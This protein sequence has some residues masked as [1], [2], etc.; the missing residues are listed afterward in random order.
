[1]TKSEIME[2]YTMEQLAEMVVKSNNLLEVLKYSDAFIKTGLFENPAVA[3]YESKIE[4][5][6]KENEKLKF[7]LDRKQ[8]EINQI[9]EILNELFGVTHDIAKPAEFEK[10]LREKA[11]DYKTISDFLPEEPIEVASMLINVEKNEE[12]LGIRDA[13]HIFDISELRQIAEHLLVYCNANKSEEE[14]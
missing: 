8:T 14:K 4:I 10:I 12:L 1:M 11:E 6:Q 5:L 3:A 9:D 7:K 13:F 2:N